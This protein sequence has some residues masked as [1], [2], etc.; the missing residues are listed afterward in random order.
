M[1]TRLDAL[2]EQRGGVGELLVL[3]MYGGLPAA[4]QLRVFDA[5][6]PGVRKLVVAT[7]IAEASVTIEGVAYV[8]DCGF[9]KMKVS[10]I[11]YEVAQCC[12]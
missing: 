2:S 6:P 1:R 11:D 3:P 8:I 7:N 10:L 9:V 12:V 5:A 4:E